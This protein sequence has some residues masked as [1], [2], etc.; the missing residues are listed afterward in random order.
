VNMIA[1]ALGLSGFPNLTDDSDG[2]I[3]RQELMEA[4]S[5]TEGE[6]AARSL[7]FRVTE[8]FLGQDGVLENGRLTLAGQP[9]PI[10]S[11]RAV[12]INYSGGPG[13]FPSVSLAD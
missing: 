1:A 7:A 6:P 12:Y 9:I 13:T 11:Q 2:F 10:D 5:L 4:P 8:K 3:R